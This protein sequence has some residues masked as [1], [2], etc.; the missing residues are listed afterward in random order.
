MRNIWIAAGAL[1]FMSSGLVAQTV[2]TVSVMAQAETTPVATLDDAA[3]DPAIWRNRRNPDQS[4]IIGTD[5]R[6]GI[7][8][9]EL[10]GKSVGFTPSPRLNNVD[11]RSKVKFGRKS[12]VIVAASDR[13]DEANAKIALFTLDTKARA[14]VPLTSLPV[15][16]GEA[17]VCACGSVSVTKPFSGSLFSK[18]AGL[19]RC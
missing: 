2:E 16:P 3:D 8:V 11:L 12:V 4:L 15:G 6:A 19:I 17:T 10:N 5:K 18:M 7:H 13:A 14:L 9:Y 1:T